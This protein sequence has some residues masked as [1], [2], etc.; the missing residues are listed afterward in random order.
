MSI[1]EFNFKDK[2]NN[3]QTNNL[4]KVKNCPNKHRC[5]KLTCKYCK[6]YGH[7]I[8]CCLK[9]TRKKKKQKQNY[10]SSNN[11]NNSFLPIEQEQ[12]FFSMMKNQQGNYPISVS[13]T[14]NHYGSYETNINKHNHQTKVIMSVSETTIV[15]YE[16]KKW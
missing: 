6:K 8:S 14:K 11:F 16:K 5:K 7:G 3:T 13:H 12:Q 1:I 15:K 10:K 2:V 9:L 4:C